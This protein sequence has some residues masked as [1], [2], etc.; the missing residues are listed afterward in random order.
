MG[1]PTGLHGTEVFYM[2]FKRCNSE[3]GRKSVKFQAEY[4]NFLYFPRKETNLIRFST[5]EGR[6]DPRAAS[7]GL[8]QYPQSV[9]GFVSGGR[10]HSD[11]AGTV[12]A[13]ADLVQRH[14]EVT[15]TKSELLDGL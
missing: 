7:Q 13:L 3:N 5:S 2:M 4:F 1:G 12:S 14:D 8:R 9:A 6:R 15:I 11:G 10:T